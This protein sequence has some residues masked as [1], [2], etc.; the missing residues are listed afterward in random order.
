MPRSLP[1]ITLLVV[2]ENKQ[3]NHSL[4]YLCRI[5]SLLAETLDGT[6]LTDKTRL[7][8]LF[9]KTNFKNGKE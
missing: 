4:H 7:S 3:C 9:N 1:E 6:G 5:T 8:D 2:D